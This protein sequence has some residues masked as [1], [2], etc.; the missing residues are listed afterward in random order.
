MVLFLTVGIGRT[1]DCLLIFLDL[2]AACLVAGGI[3][4]SLPLVQVA[5]HGQQVPAQGQLVIVQAHI[6]FIV[7]K[8][9][10]RPP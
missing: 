4:L 2:E 7:S 6:G 10:P 3:Q 1:A 9:K 5:V 8:T